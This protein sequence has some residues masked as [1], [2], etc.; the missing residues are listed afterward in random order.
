MSAS[1]RS[2]GSESRSSYSGQLPGQS[3]L[4]ASAPPPPSPHPVTS[5]VSSRPAPQSPRPAT[6]I[7]QASSST[8]PQ[9][10]PPSQAASSA[11]MPTSRQ[12]LGSSQ[13]Q[14]VILKRSTS[15]EAPAAIGLAA[16]S[17]P[18]SQRRPSRRMSPTESSMPRQRYP[19][20]AGSLA[21]PPNPTATYPRPFSP[22]PLLQ[23][24]A[25]SSSRRN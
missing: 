12:T 4:S 14:T 23:S 19:V 22:A 16:S 15:R 25:P 18:V 3:A 21:S 13:S 8:R 11:T 7:L 10:L 6:M 20:E 24:Q 17:N 1:S 2:R 9:V 5:S